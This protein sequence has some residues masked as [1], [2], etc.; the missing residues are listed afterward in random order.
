MVRKLT[1]FGNSLALVIDPA[2]LNRLDIG[3]DTPLD[4]TTDGEALIISPVREGDRR[5]QNGP[6]KGGRSPRR[7]RRA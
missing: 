5:R 1:R 2:L 4:I 3:S 6:A 7:P